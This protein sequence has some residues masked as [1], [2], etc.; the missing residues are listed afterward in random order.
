MEAQAQGPVR[1][2][3]LSALDSLWRVGV[4]GDWVKDF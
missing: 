4:G 3:S 2:C 1:G